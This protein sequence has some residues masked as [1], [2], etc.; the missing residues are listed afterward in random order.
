MSSLQLPSEHYSS[1][2]IE[3]SAI[4]ENLATRAQRHHDKEMK[5]GRFLQGKI[6]LLQLLVYRDRNLYRLK[7]GFEA[8]KRI[9][10]VTMASSH[11]PPP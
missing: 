7:R 5:A 1:S 6:C 11:S 8:F 4:K 2:A 10:A 3:S 9:V